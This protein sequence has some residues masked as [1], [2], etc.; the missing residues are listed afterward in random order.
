M[1]TEKVYSHVTEAED[2]VKKLC[3]KYKEVMWQVDP[4]I[5]AVLGV[6]NKKRGKKDHALARIKP[7]HG[8]EK[9]LLKENNINT[10]YV[11]SLYWSDWNAW[12]NK[13]KQAVIFHELLHVYHEND[14][15][16]NHDLEDFCILI[17]SLGVNWFNSEKLPDLINDKVD[18]DLKLRPG[19]DEK[20]DDKEE[21]KDEEDDEKDKPKTPKRK[22]DPDPED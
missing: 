7:I 14:K 20:E 5:V 6:E 16:L 10:R 22:F 21:E 8:C 17:S 11:I 1:A 19:L 2:I 9:A 3:E 18:F 4:K 12:N 13:Q 15:V